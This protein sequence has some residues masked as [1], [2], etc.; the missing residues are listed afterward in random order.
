MSDQLVPGDV[1]MDDIGHYMLLRQDMMVDDDDVEKDIW[2][3]LWLENGE[4][5]WCWACMIE[6]EVIYRRVA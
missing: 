2:W 5:V 3:M 1:L 4:Q 6:D